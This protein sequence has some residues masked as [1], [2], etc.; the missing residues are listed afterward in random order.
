MQWY[1]QQQAELQNR[2]NQL[3]SELTASYHTAAAASAAAATPTKKRGRSRAPSASSSSSSSSVALFRSSSTSQLPSY[4]RCPDPSEDLAA[5]VN[6]PPVATASATPT[7]AA[8]GYLPTKTVS[9]E[10]LTLVA[11]AGTACDVF[12][13]LAAASSEV[14]GNVSPSA[15]SPAASSRKPAFP[16]AF[17]RSRL[18]SLPEE[19]HQVFSVFFP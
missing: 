19:N 12:H 9:C 10:N 18:T 17:L 11:G 2:N 3:N 1:H 6:R 13:P 7:P 14:F 16:Y 15:A 5:R 8:A 4:V